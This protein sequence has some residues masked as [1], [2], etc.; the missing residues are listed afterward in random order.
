MAEAKLTPEMRE[1]QV[2]HKNLYLGGGGTE[3]HIVRRTC[4]AIR[5]WTCLTAA[6]HDRPYV[7]P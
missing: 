3:G 7:R 6:N 5:K 2:E 1:W 4:Q